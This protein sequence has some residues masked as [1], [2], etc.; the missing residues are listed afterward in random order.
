MVENLKTSLFGHQ[1]LVSEKSIYAVAVDGSNH[2]EVLDGFLAHTE[3]D[4]RSVQ[5]Q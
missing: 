5:V 3:G 4:I 1:F 2:V